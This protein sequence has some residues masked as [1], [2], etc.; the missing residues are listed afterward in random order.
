MATGGPVTGD[1][2]SGAIMQPRYMGRVMDT[3]PVSD[4]E[5]EVISSLSADTTTSYSFATF[6]LGLGASI[7]INATFYT[8]FTPEA[9][10]A[11][12]YIAPA[13]MLAALYCAMRGFQMHRRRRSAWEKIKQSSNPVE[14]F[15]TPIIVRS[16]VPAT[17]PMSGHHQLHGNY[18][19]PVQ[20]ASAPSAE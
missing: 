2:P 9:K 1:V 18:S 16:E 11:V 13:L 10:I 8:E 4:S 5:M 17:A 19:A 3:Y 12:K 7:W 15:A 20:S 14:A 6:W